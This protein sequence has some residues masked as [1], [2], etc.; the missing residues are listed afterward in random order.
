MSDKEVLEITKLDGSNYSMWKFGITFLLQ[1]KELTGFV[2]GTEDEPDKETKLNDWKTWMKKSSQAAVI[3]LS[4]VEK[5]LHPNLINCS[6]PQ[7]IWDKI[8]VLYGDT[9]VDAK[10]SAWEQFYAF[11]MTDSQSIALQI[12][13]LESICKKLEDAGEKP[14]DTAVV[15]KLLSSLPPKFSVF[16][17]AWDCT[18]E[19]E[20]KKVN[21]IARLIREDKRLSGNEE[22]V[23]ELAFQVQKT[24]LETRSTKEQRKRNIQDLKK[25]TKCAICKEKGHWARECPKKKNGSEAAAYV[26]DVIASFSS[27]CDEDSE[28]WIAD[29]G[30]SMHMTYNNEYFV[31][32]EAPAEE[33][34]VKVADDKILKASGKGT[35]KIQENIHGRLQERE[36]RNVLFVPDLK[37]N[38]FS[39]GTISNNG[40]SFHAYEEKCEIRDRDGKLSSVGVRYKNLYRML[41]EVKVPAD[42][43]VAQANGGLQSDILKLWHERMTHVNIRA[44]KNTCKQLEVGEL[45][46]EKDFFCEACVTGKQSRKHHASVKSGTC[47]KP[48]E[49]IHTDVCGPVNIESPR[50]SKYFLLFKDECTSFRKVYFLRHKSEVFEKFREFQAFVFTQLNTKIKVLK[51]DNG[52]EYTSREFDKYLRDNGIVHELSSAYIHEQNGRAEREIR[53][54]VESA[55]SILFAKSVD[56]KL[57][58]EAINTVCYVLNRVI[59]QPSEKETPYEKWFGRRPQIKH[60]KVFGVDAYLNIPKE[61]RTKFQPKSRKLLF[62]GYDGESN[63]YRLWD[64]EKNKIYISSDVDFNEQ[65]AVEYKNSQLIIDLDFNIP[66]GLPEAAAPEQVQIPQQEIM[67]EAAAPEQ[68]QAPQQDVMDASRVLRDR[69]LLHPPDRY[70]IPVAF[71][72]H[73]VPSN[74]SQA[75]ISQDA[76]K[77]KMAMNEEIEALND[78]K[79]WTLSEL[80]RGKRLTGC[81]WVFTVKTDPAGNIE[82]YKARL[83]AKGFSQREGIDYFETYAPVVRY[84]SIRLLLA[85]AASRDYEIKKFDVKT[86]FLYGE[87]QEEIYLEQPEGYADPNNP[88]FVCKLHKSLY[89]LKQSPRCWNEKF[90]GFLKTFSF[91]PCE[92]DKCVFIGQVNGFTVYLAL[93]VDDGLIMCEKMSAIDEV[94]SVLKGKFKITVGSASDFVGLEIVRN[95]KQRL[96]TINQAGYVNKLV[97]KFAM[98]DAKISSIPADPGSYLRKNPEN[99][100]STKNIPYREAVGSLL[101]AARV[102]RPDIE[103]AVNYASQFLDCY[104]QEHW[105]FVKKILRY[106]KGTVDFGITFGNSGSLDS[107]QGF[108]DADYAGCLDTRKSRS[109][110]VFILN[111]APVSWSSQRQCI[112]SLSTAESEYI[113]LAHGVK[114]AVWLRQFLLDLN[115]DFKD[116]VIFVDNQAAIKLASNSEHHKRS[117]HIDVRFHFIRDI[118]NN[119]QVDLRYIPTTDQLADIFT[120]PLAKKQF[121]YLRSQLNILDPS[122]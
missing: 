85:I 49:K 8:K 19:A 40:F 47:Y 39:I 14:S 2:L 28:V 18:P 22:N 36:L 83:V 88:D 115:V 102:S 120:K 41:F 10:Q 121:S 17:M 104:T 54:L 72:A 48:G 35:I 42:C 99:I 53:T 113:A 20:R 111:G 50:G 79:T 56:S 29:S 12:E 67:D 61:K 90:V 82:R 89:G 62:V 1:A 51:S 60:L 34:L 110:F 52:T 9:S 95:R 97:D 122:K 64:N 45:Q 65:H 16:R 77:W 11:K 81:R 6:T 101:F 15:S 94:L 78:N 31:Y 86:A 74:Y 105:Q 21:L 55:R 112:V 33:Y 59:L 106:L 80:P 93:Y 3:L 100:H 24:S 27:T 71:F 4:S 44:V 109:G 116:V 37:R 98:Q 23:T 57:W 117:K 58:P 38:L 46:A 63:N 43:N 84:E 118:V 75:A 13:K 91:L 96:L 119:K 73:A 92:S 70:G 69:N 103:Y 108:T 114:E 7:E 26:S 76:E 25:R 68:I 32:L 30:A 5:K 107:L 66:E 87:L